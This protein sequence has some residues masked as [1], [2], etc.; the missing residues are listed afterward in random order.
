M[1]LDDLGVVVQWGCQAQELLG[2]TAADVIGQPAAVLVAETTAPSRPGARPGAAAVLRNRDGCEVAVD[3][4]V[5]PM[6]RPDRSIAWAMYRAAEEAAADTGAAVLEAFFKQ[7]PQGLYLLDTDLRLVRVNTATRNLPDMPADG[8]LGRRFTDVFDLSAPGETEAVVHEVLDSGVPAL[9]RLVR[10]RP[11][12]STGLGRLY[13]LSVLR[14]EDAQGAVLGAALAAIDVTVSEAEHARTEVLNTVHERVGQTLDV[15]ANCEELVDALVPGFADAAVVDVVDMVLRG[16]EP[17][18]GPL[19][20]EVPLRRAAY[21]ASDRWSPAYPVGD[22]RRLPSSTPYAQA[23]TD[24]RP[25][26]LT[27]GPDT[28]WLTADPSRAE[29]I[30]LSGAHSLIVAPLALRGTALGLLNLYR[31]QETGPYDKQDLALALSLATYTALCIDNARRYTREHTIAVTTQR[32][33]LPQCPA[34][35]ATVE[36]AHLHRPGDRGGGGWFDIMELSGGRTGLVVGEVAGHG[37]NTVATMGQLRTAIHSLAALGLDPDELLARLNDTAMALAEERAALP[38]GDPLRREKLAASC[39]YAEYDP[40]ARTCTVARAGHPAPVIN[41]PNE[42]TVIPDIPTG[43]LLGSLD[44]SPFTAVTLELIDGS[45]MAFYTPAFLSCHR[46]SA[47]NALALLRQILEHPCRDLPDLCDEALYACQADDS[48]SAGDAILLLARTHSFPADK[49]ATWPLGY[50][51]AAAGTA[52]AH[53]RSQLTEWKIDEATSDTAQL[54]VS[55][56]V[57]N[58]VRYGSPPLELRLIRD[59][60]LTCEVHDNSATAPRVCHARAFDEGGRGLFITAHLAHKWGYRYT[61]DG[62]IVWTEQRL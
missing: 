21:R 14:L 56:L 62:K 20:R 57:T 4:R 29:V 60:M 15:L 10:G 2:Y 17:T 42:A 8:G 11:K 47:Q 28:A 16:E 46:P 19:G 24:F 37:I 49:V 41:F 59:H 52:R 3:L 32:Q 5:R 31:T 40:L 39:V 54:I 22:V 27:L 33:L 35:Q 30:R 53:V 55:E 9:G 38:L 50:D 61:S 23:L 12:G 18:A 58:A 48:S 25:R 7:W 6:L 43:P 45:V 13:S 44:G 34:S 26:L 1:V 51:T 36:T